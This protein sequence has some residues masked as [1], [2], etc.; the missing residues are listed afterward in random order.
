VP[1]LKQI[2]DFL[3]KQLAIS[4]YQDG[5]NNGLQVENRSEIKR[6]CCGVDASMEFFQ[7]AEATGANL[8]VCH[9]GLSWGNSLKRISGLNYERVSYLINND[10]ALYDC[11]LPLDAHPQPLTGFACGDCSGK[12]SRVS[13]PYSPAPC[14]RGKSL[15]APIERQL[16]PYRSSPIWVCPFFYRGDSCRC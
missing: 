2:T 16:K 10:I 3:D 1:H 14:A 7:A 4:D 5:S 8:L 6:V 13:N 15:R 9:H 12:T 11:H